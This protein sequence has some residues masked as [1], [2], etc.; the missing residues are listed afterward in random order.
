MAENDEH[1]LRMYV[2]YVYP[3]ANAFLTNSLS[4]PNCVCIQKN[5]QFMHPSPPLI[6]FTI[7]THTRTHTRTNIV[8]FSI[9]ILWSAIYLHFV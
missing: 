2:F 6:T 3:I 1:M 9:N 5:I 4:N 7:P 8:G